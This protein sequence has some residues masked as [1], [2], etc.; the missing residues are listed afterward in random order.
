V[1]A[2]LVED[3]A[4]ALKMLVHAFTS[5]GYEVDSAGNGAEAIEKIPAAR[6]DIVIMDVMMP[7]MDGMEATR[8]LRD[9]PDTAHIPIILLTARD[10]IEDKLTG[11]DSGADDY[12]VKPVMPAELIARSNAFIR[13]SQQHVEQAPLQ[14]GRVIGF[15]GVKG[16]IGT[17]S[18]VVNL[19]VALAQKERRVILAD[20]HPWV[21][22]AALFMG[23]MPRAS[24]AMLKEQEP[25]AI[26]QRMVE[27]S[28][29]R[30]RSGVQV[31]AVPMDATVRIGDLDPDQVTA[32]IDRLETMGD[33]ILLDLGNGITPISMAAIK[34]CHSMIMVL[35]GDAISID[36]GTQLVKR[37][38]EAGM[39][40]SRLNLVVINRARSAST[41]TREEIEG[42]LE[43][44][45]LALVTP[46]P[47][48]FFHANKSGVPVLI[49]QPDTIVAAQM[50]E[51][52]GKL[53]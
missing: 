11:F 3:N 48:I 41:Y 42:L 13:R 6:P 8:R 4:T 44:K 47:E 34:C 5:A 9:N 49:E 35:D 27:E 29:E 24:V 1:K 45:L 40:G 52:S 39:V 14:R 51:L 21:G 23:L 36:L 50:R 7:V 32:V 28:L 12:V 2:F 22:T 17:T 26:S 18:L 16:G 53:L 15:L 46:A 33:L 43:S 20:L 31:F 25:A 38:R 37:F 19:S 10:R 30:H